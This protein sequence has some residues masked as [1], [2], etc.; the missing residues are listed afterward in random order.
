MA[1]KKNIVFTAILAI[2]AVVFIASLVWLQGQTSALRKITTEKKSTREEIEGY[3]K[4]KPTKEHEAQLEE[5]YE[6]IEAS[7]DAL[8]KDRLMIWWDKDVYDVKKS[9]TEPGLFL[10]RLQELRRQVATFANDQEVLLGTGVENLDFPELAENKPPLEVTIEMHKECSAVRDIIMLLLQNKVESIN[11]IKRMG[12]QAGGKLYGKYLFSVS[13]SCKYPALATFQTDLV[14]KMKVP[15]GTYGDF[16]RN[17][18]VVER[19]S[20]VA[21]DLKVAAM[22][23]AAT[24]TTTTGSNRNTRSNP[25]GGRMPGPSGTVRQ[26]P[27]YGNQPDPGSGLAPT[28]Y[29]SMSPNSRGARAAGP[30]QKETYR[31]GREPN[32]NIL[33]V[34]MTISMV[35]FSE[36]LTG[37]IP[38]LEEKEEDKKTPSGSKVS[39]T[40]SMGP[41]R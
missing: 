24:T 20:Y 5:Q 8:T 34:T 30:R 12:P 2:L 21:Q 27:N 38:G 31:V 23:A 11:S 15:V 4:D 39:T 32:Y 1:L 3:L 35:D 40:S 37:A 14:N 22:E 9:P 13:F 17:Y 41:G 19:L 28:R 18:L 16:P 6:Q 7:Y 10:G 29:G 36:E 33:T 25:A 26:P